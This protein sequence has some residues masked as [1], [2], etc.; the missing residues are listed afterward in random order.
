MK[1]GT[2]NVDVLMRLRSGWLLSLRKKRLGE[3]IPIVVMLMVMLL[4][5]MVVSN[6]RGRVVTVNSATV[7]IFHV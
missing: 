2:C 4:V 6:F 3:I 1:I 7:V 5:M